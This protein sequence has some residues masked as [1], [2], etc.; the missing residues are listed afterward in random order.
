VAGNELREQTRSS[1]YAIKKEAALL[2]Y[3][4]PVT[5]RFDLLPLIAVTPQ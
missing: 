3:F 4:A 1:S 5:A 2:R